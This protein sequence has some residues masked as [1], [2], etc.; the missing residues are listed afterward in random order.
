MTSVAD[1]GYDD[2]AGYPLNMTLWGGNGIAFDYGGDGVMVLSGSFVSQP[3]SGMGK[4]NV[5]RP[6][7]ASAQRHAPRL[8]N[9]LQ[10]PLLLH[11]R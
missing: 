6:A 5:R 3:A 10:R 7:R 4:A 2:S 8:S 1:L 11:P 9:V